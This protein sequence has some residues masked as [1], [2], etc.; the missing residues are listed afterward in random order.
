RADGAFTAL[1]GVLDLALALDLDAGVLTAARLERSRLRPRLCQAGRELESSARGLGVVER[2]RHV[3]AGARREDIGDARERDAPR[4]RVGR[5][6]EVARVARVFV[7]A[8]GKSRRRAVDV[9]R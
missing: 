7:E 3:V 9:V 1:T 4:C 8:A 2:D 5:G 6:L